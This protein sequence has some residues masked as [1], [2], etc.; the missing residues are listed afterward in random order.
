MLASTTPVYAAAKAEVKGKSTEERDVRRAKKEKMRAEYK[1]AQASCA[2]DD[3]CIEKVREAHKAKRKAMRPAG[4]NKAKTKKP[5]RP[6]R[7]KVKRV[8]R[9]PAEKAARKVA[10][11]KRRAERA[12]RKGKGH[13]GKG[14]KG[15]KAKK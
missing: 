10:T 3:A 2:E 1:A 7:P 4:S 13:K 5:A 15:K 11:D 12:A 9:T 6:K 8:E 14:P